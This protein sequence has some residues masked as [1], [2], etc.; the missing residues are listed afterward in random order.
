M[1]AAS[2]RDRLLLAGLIPPVE[3]V[4]DADH[5]RDH[6]ERLDDPND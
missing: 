3:P 2:A 6:D 4:E 5:D 1:S